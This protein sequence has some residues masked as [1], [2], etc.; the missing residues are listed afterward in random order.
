ML[1]FVELQCD[2]SRMAPYIERVHNSR[3]AFQMWSFTW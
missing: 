1:Y 2:F 3:N